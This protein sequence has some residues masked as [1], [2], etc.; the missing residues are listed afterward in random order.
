MISNYQI[1]KNKIRQ[2][3]IAWQ[4]FASMQNLSLNDLILQADY[5]ATVGKKYGLIKEFKENGIL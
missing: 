2:E 5:F 1:K 3:A 4:Q